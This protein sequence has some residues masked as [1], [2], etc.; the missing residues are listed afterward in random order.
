MSCNPS[1][2]S[3]RGK[4][5]FLKFLSIFLTFFAVYVI[6]IFKQI[7]LCCEFFP[8]YFMWKKRF[9]PLETSSSK[10][11]N[12]DRDLYSPNGKNEHLLFCPWSSK[13]RPYL[14][15]TWSD[16]LGST[17]LF[18]QPK[19]EVGAGGWWTNPELVTQFSPFLACSNTL[20]AIS[21][22]AQGW[23]TYQCSRSLSNF[24]K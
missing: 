23:R 20:Q 9:F 19:R 2:V 22:E 10:C 18:I 21:K 7:V 8:W 17:S 12:S 5:P 16:V 6:C 4:K 24:W 15:W 11:L 1:S 14:N 3:L 13:P